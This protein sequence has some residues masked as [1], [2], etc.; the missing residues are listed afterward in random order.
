LGS[1]LSWILVEEETPRLTARGDKKG[2][3]GM[4]YP[5]PVLPSVSRGIPRFA[6]DGVLHFVRDGVPRMP[7]RGGSGVAL[8]RLGIAIKVIWEDEALL[9]IRGGLKEAFYGLKGQGI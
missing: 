8:S 5:N 6:R 2:M 1:P 9:E 7:K 4:T 3:L